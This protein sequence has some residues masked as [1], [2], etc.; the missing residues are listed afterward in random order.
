[1]PSVAPDITN[2]DSRNTGAAAVAIAEVAEDDAADR[3][4]EIA[5]RERGER[6]HQRDERRS[7]WERSRRRCPC[8]KMP[9]MTK[10]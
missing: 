5:G 10:S 4:G 3:P 8:A 9:K 7:G 1:M 2:T 6:D